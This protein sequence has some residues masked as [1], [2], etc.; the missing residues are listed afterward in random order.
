MKV[1]CW[2]GL[3]LVT[4]AMHSHNAAAFHKKRQHAGIQ[5]AHMAEFKKSVPQDNGLNWKTWNGVATNLRPTC[6]C[7]PLC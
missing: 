4:N 3:A 1:A 7:Q 5:L 6:F 2:N